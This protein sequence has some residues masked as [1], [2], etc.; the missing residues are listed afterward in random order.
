MKKWSVGKPD[1]NIISQLILKCGISSLAAAVLAAKGYSSP[2]TVFQHFNVDQL[3]DPFMIKDMQKASD[4]INMAI[5]NEDKICIYGDY[6]CDGIMS[7]V[8][9]YSF[10]SETGA[11]VLYYIP[12]RTEGYG[13]NENTV[14]KLSDNSVKLIITV[15]NGISAIN[16]AE[17][18]Y[19]L[20]MKL[21]VTDHHQPGESLPRAEAVVDPH[22]NDCFSPFKYLCGAGVV[23]KLIAALD[24]GDYTMALEQFGDLAAI[25]TIA[26]IVNITGENRFIVSYGMQLI[27][28]TD[29]PSVDALKEVCGLS[30]KKIDSYSIGFGLSPRINAAGRFGSP[31][32]AAE[33]FLCEDPDIARKYASDLDEL[34]TKRKKNEELIMSDIYAMIDKNPMLIRTRTIFLCGKNWHHG[35]IGIIAARIMEQ[36]GKPVFIASEENGEIRG[37]ARSFGDF[38]IFNALNFCKDTLE[39]FGG[40]PGAGG[41]TI[42]P[43]RIHDFCILLEKYALEYHKNMPVLTINADSPVTPAELTVP[44]VNGL[45][46]LEPFGNGNEKPLF[47]M[48]NAIIT[49]ITPLSHGAHSK[50]KL[51]FGFLQTDALFFRTPPEKLNVTNGDVCDIIVTLDVNNFR[52]K[53]NISII[54]KDIRLHGTEQNKYF[55]ANSAF[56]CF[57]RNEQLPKNYYPSMYP[58]YDEAKMIYVSIPDNGIHEDSLYLKCSRS[59]LNY[60]KFRISLEAMRQLGLINVSSSDGCVTKVRVNA[61]TDL[62]SAP[63]LVSLKNKLDSLIS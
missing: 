23:L 52:S 34:N 25:A 56:E 51:K 4:T 14:R 13:L 20:G 8:M 59:G 9:L 50:L 62:F 24:G 38:S 60:C 54:I 53:E 3:S 7:T 30:E 40:H 55:A 63:I 61:K 10:L 45:K 48:E 57:I 16:E 5:D 35:V 41:F 46:L 29:R 22:R 2:E 28:N 11:D 43:D 49:G 33:L 6:D 26:D 37:S 15:D 42:K 32:T 47:F 39:K 21:V 17:L 1:R 27:E 44:N 12:E 36:F 58:L 31:K 19:E 18:I